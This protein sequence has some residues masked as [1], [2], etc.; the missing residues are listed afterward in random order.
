MTRL[1]TS[2]QTI[3]PCPRC[4]RL[5]RRVHRW[6]PRTLAARPGAAYRMRRQVQGRTFFYGTPDGPRRICPERLL[7]VA[8][9]GHAGPVDWHGA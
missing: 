9:P 5:T 7:A 1:L 3:V 8:A 6:Y 2:T 4:P